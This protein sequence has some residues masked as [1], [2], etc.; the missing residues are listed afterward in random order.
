MTELQ[1]ILRKVMQKLLQNEERIEILLM[2]FLMK[3]QKDMMR[4]TIT[5]TLYVLMK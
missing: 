1:M 3:L 4:P 2:M 5:R